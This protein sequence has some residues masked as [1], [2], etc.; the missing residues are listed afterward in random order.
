MIRIG[1]VDLSLNINEMIPSDV[2]EYAKRRVKHRR[3]RCIA[4]FSSVL[5]IATI[6]AASYW[7][8]IVNAELNNLMFFVVS[9]FVAGALISKFPFPLFNKS[10]YGKITNI[11]VTDALDNEY[12]YAGNSRPVPLPRKRFVDKQLLHVDSYTKNKEYVL[13]THSDKKHKFRLSSA[14]NVGDDII[15][16]DGTDYAFKVPNNE[17]DK[18]ICVICGHE[19]AFSADVCTAC[20]YALIK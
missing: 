7:E 17:N 13:K 16:L 3:I 14:Y 15:C 8:D 5:V 18:R 9:V 2:V 11:D 1:G 12:V 19:N 6:I 10:I 4:L 20:S